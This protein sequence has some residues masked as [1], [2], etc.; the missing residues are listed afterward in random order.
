MPCRK[1]KRKTRNLATPK[2]KE[3]PLKSLKKGPI[4]KGNFIFQAP[5]S[6]DN[7]LVFGGVH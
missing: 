3:W 6:R 1:K 4:L 2:M 7:I 5:F